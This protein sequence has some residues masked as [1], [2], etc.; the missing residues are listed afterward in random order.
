ILTLIVT[1]CTESIGFVH[2][3]SLRSALASESR[4]RFNT[5][6]RLLTAARGWYNPNGALLNGISAVLLIISYSSA[7]VVIC[8]D[9]NNSE[10][11]QMLAIAGVPLFVL[12]VA[13]FLQAMI[14]LSGMWT[15]KILTW[16]SSPFD[17]TAALVHHAQL[18]PTTFRC[19]RCVSEIDTY[20]GPAKP[21]ETQPSAWHAH[22]SIRKVVISLWVI[23]AAC[24]GWAVLVM[25]VWHHF[26]L[27]SQFTPYPLTRQTWS[28][29]PSAQSNAIVYSL[30]GSDLEVG[31]LFYVHTI[32]L[33]GPLTLVL[34]CSELIANVIRDER[35]WR[36]A[37]RTKGL[38]VTT[39]LL[40]STLNHPICLILF[41]AKPF[42]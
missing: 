16:S 1:L 38:K 2:G 20:G 30:S 14:A 22:S 8:L 18:T 3:V 5:N 6:L 36:C 24:A 41:I 15:V 29:F 17:V 9:L 27:S 40:V 25:Y 26:P 35:Q 33:Q 42:L 28:F 31:I 10:T 39:N 7:S 13:L 19:M 23:V 34:H 21:S 11:F 12:G 4:L 37:T 32:F